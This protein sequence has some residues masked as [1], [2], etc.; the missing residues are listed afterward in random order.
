[1]VLF[2]SMMFM[3]Y[4]LNLSRPFFQE[5]DNVDKFKDTKSV[6]DEK[7][8]EP[9]DLAQLGRMPESVTL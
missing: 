1:M 7:G 5:K 8:D 4:R 2:M 9:P 6:K 3:M